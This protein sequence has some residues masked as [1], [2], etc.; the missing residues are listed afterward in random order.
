MECRPVSVSTNWTARDR[1]T[2]RVMRAVGLLAELSEGVARMALPAPV[3][4]GCLAKAALVKAGQQGR[5]DYDWRRGRE[6][7]PQITC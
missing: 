3:A 2:Y 4:E 5:S 6:L 1:S 7:N